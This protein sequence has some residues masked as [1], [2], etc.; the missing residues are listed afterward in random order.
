MTGT[1]SSVVLT[2]DPF[3][4]AVKLSERGR[5]LQQIPFGMYLELG[6]LL[7]HS[8]SHS[9]GSP[10]TDIHQHSSFSSHLSHLLAA[11]KFVTC[12]PTPSKA[13]TNH[14]HVSRCHT[15][16]L[17]VTLK[18][19]KLDRT[20]KNVCLPINTSSFP[21]FLTTC[22]IFYEDY[23][24]LQIPRYIHLSLSMFS[25]GLIPCRF[26]IHFILAL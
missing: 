16:T 17:G 18:A 4:Q 19:V 25:F 23:F 9:Y 26:S 7:H 2:L 15:V 13:L 6:F 3:E 11:L 22:L 14:V 1:L 10:Q 20:T 12:T 8:F 21:P 5:L 24:T